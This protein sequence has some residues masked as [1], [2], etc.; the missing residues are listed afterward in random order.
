MTFLLVSVSL[1]ESGCDE[2]RVR[3]GLDLV[4]IMLVHTIVHDVIQVVQEADDL[5]SLAGLGHQGEVHN[6]AVLIQASSNRH[7]NWYIE[8]T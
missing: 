7:V 4:D 3:D 1:W 5:Q 2:V 8:Y 6:R